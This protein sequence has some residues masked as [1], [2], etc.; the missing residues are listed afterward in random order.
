[1][2]TQ[3]VSAQVYFKQ[4]PMDPNAGRYGCNNTNNILS[5]CVNDIDTDTQIENAFQSQFG[6][7][8]YYKT[9]GVFNAIKRDYIDQTMGNLESNF[10]QELNKQQYTMNE[11]NQQMYPV[12]TPLSQESQQ[13]KSSFGGEIKTKSTFGALSGSSMMYIIIILLAIAAYFYLKK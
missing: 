7:S 6:L 9:P 13:S 2:E 3:N 10:N 4:L 11:T 12:Q 8:E 1:M 5:T